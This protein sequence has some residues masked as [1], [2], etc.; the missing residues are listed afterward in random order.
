MTK[1]EVMDALKELRYDVQRTG[2][3]S[4]VA[5]LMF[6]IDAVRELMKQ[7]VPLTLE[8]LLEM[9]GEPVWVRHRHGGEWVIAHWNALDIIA[10]ALQDVLFKHE[11]GETWLA[12]R[13]KVKEEHHA[14][15]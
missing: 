3:A 13:H 1:I 7:D 11:Y 14:E 9:E 10:G 15:V 8:E 2:S 12:F 4:S 6:A 5:A